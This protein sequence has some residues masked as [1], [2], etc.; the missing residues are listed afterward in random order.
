[1]ADSW[2]LSHPGGV[3]AWAK[4]VAGFAELPEYAADVAQCLAESFKRDQMP[5][6]ERLRVAQ[7]E[8]ELAQKRQFQAQTML[9]KLEKQL[10]MVTDD[11]EALAKQEEADGYTGRATDLRDIIN[12]A[13]PKTALELVDSIEGHMPPGCRKQVESEFRRLRKLIR[14]KP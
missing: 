12:P 5:I 11:I 7:S 8:I 2:N 13:A 14:D 3:L 4:T 6:D 10:L 9:S 1:M